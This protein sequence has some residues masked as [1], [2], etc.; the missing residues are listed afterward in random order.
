MVER[1]CASSALAAASAMSLRA[2]SLATWSG[3]G[4]YSVQA[5][6]CTTLGVHFFCGRC[7]GVFALFPL[8]GVGSMIL[9]SASF[10]LHFG[11][12]FPCLLGS[13]RSFASSGAKRFVLFTGEAGFTYLG[14][15]VPGMVVH[16]PGSYASGSGDGAQ[17]A[18]LRGPCTS[19]Q[20]SVSYTHLTLPTKRIV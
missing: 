14:F 6:G 5:L 15:Q 18:S 17:H 1:L 2:L 19:C 20:C 13:G 7:P 9:P 3:H 8:F 10:N 4:L 16:S 12:L 11:T